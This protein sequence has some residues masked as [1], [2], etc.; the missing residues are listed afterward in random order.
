MRQLI[1]LP[2]YLYVRTTGCLPTDGRMT[3][4]QSI[5]QEKYVFPGPLSWSRF[6]SIDRSIVVNTG[7]WFDMALE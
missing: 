2:L 6:E 1:E 5:P 7:I 3:Q 4:F